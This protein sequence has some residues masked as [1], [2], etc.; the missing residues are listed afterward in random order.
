VTKLLI[1]LYFVQ[2]KPRKRAILFTC[3]GFV[4]ASK[5]SPAGNETGPAA[6][7]LPGKT[8]VPNPSS[9]PRRVRVLRGPA[10]YD[11]VYDVRVKAVF[12]T[13]AP[14]SSAEEFELKGNTK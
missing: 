6:A 3:S 8:S 9:N 2:E 1:D 14:R 5:K 13:L 11:G 12:E 7:A 4:T 10:T